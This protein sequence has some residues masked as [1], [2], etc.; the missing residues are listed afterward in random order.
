LVTASTAITRIN[1]KTNQPNRK[2]LMVPRLPAQWAVSAKGYSLL[3]KSVN[4]LVAA[5]VLVVPVQP[6]P[7]LVQRA[8]PGPQMRLVP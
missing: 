1:Y 8:L 5:G 3:S 2:R 7:M 4:S 6:Q